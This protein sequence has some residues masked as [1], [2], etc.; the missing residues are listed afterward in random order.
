MR[1]AC[2]GAGKLVSFLCL[3]PGGGWPARGATTDSFAIENHSA[4]GLIGASA[5]GRLYRALADDGRRTVLLKTAAGDAPDAR[6]C[7]R[8][9]REY[10]FLAGLACPGVPR[11]QGILETAVSPVLV[12]EDRGGDLLESLMSGEPWPLPM[13]FP[14]ALSLVSALECLHRNHVVHRNIQPLSILFNQAE[15]EAHLINFQFASRVS[16]EHAALGAVEEIEGVLAYL[17]PEQTGRMNRAV[18]YRADFY[19]LGVIFYELL[20]G[21][22]P[23]AAADALE[24]V[25]CH[26]ARAPRA[27]TSVVAAIPE[28]LS[29]IVLRLLAKLAEDRY[30]SAAGLHHDLERCSREWRSV[31]RVEPF[32]IGLADNSDRFQLPQRLYGR[33]REAEILLEAFS[34]VASCGR[35]ELV[36][37]SG[38]SGI[39]KSALVAEL[40][41]PILERRGYFIAGKFDQYRRDRPYETLAEPFKSLV[42]QLLAESGER[43]AAWRTRILDAVGELGQLIV[44]LIPQI[45]LVIG[46]Q[47]SVPELPPDQAQYRL[48]RVFRRFVAAFTQPEQPLVL[49]FDDLQWVDTTSLNLLSLL[50]GDANT[51]H[52]LV[53]GAYRDNEVDDAHP[54]VSMLD[55]LRATTLPIHSLTLNPLTQH[56]VR[57]IIAATLRSGAAEVGPLAN[58]VY[59]KTRG[60]PFFTFQFLEMLHKDHLITFEAATGQWLWDVAAIRSRNFTDNVVELMLNEL[61]RLPADSREALT[62][63]GFLGNRFELT[64][65][66]LVCEE[67][68]TLTMRRLWPAIK[69][70]LLIHRYGEYH[71]LH[72]RVQEAAYL[73]TPVGDRAAMHAQI[74]RLLLHADAERLDERLFDIAAH[75]NAGRAVIVDQ[76]ERVGTAALNQRAGVRARKAAIFTAAGNYYGAGISFLPANPWKAHYDLALALHLGLA[77]CEYLQG[78]FLEAE[79]LLDIVVENANSSIDRA[80]AHMVRISLLVARGDSPAACRVA[81]IGLTD[82]GLDLVEHP[83]DEDIRRGYEEVQTLLAGRPVEYL[84]ELPE[85]ADPNMAMATRM[86]IFTSTAAYMTDVKLLA[87]HDTQMIVQCLRHGNVDSTVLGYVFYG[88][89]VANY[90]GRYREGYRFCEVAR[91]LME[92]RGLS[93]HRGSLIY[94]SAIVALWVRPI[95][96]CIQRLHDS[97]QPLL[98]SGNLVIA[99]IASRLIVTF[100]MLRGDALATVDEDAERCASFVA[101]LNYPAAVSLNRT[102]QQLIRR[103]RGSDPPVLAPADGSIGRGNDRIPFVIVAEHLAEVAWHCLMDQH[104]SAYQALL[105][106]RPL[107]WGTIGLL[108]IHDFFFYGSIS[109]AVR[110]EA[111]A[112]SERPQLLAWL[113]ANLEQLRLW[114]EGNPESF[115]A[116]RLLVAAEIARLEARSVDAL[117][118]FDEAMEAAR[119]NG[120]VQMH[121]LACERAALLCRALGIN[122]ASDRLLAQACDSYHQWGAAAKVQQMRSR[123]AYLHRFFREGSSRFSL[124]DSGPQ[125]AGVQGLDALALARASRAIA[126]QLVR[127]DLLRTLMEVMLESGGAQ[128]GA[129][130]MIREGEAVLVATAEVQESGIRTDL[131]PVGGTASLPWSLLAYVIRSREA[132][133]IDDAQR[134]HRFGSEPWFA[135]RGTRSALGLPI[136]HSRRLIGV[137]Y[138]EHRTVPDVFT[139]GQLSIMEQLAAQAAVSIENSQ[140][141]ERLEDH[142]RRLQE[143]VEQ[144]TAELQRSRNTLQSIIEHSPAMMFLKDLDGRYLAHSPSLAASF[145][146]AGQSIIGL[147]D[148]DLWPNRADAENIRRSD[149]EVARTDSSVSVT[150]FNVTPDGTRTFM[151]CKFAVPDEQGRTYAVGAVALDVTE[152]KAAK[153]AAESAT[154]AKSEFLANVSHEIRT[155]MNAILGMSHLALQTDLDPQQRDYVRKVERSA[156]LLLGV[157]NDI[158]DFSKIEAGKLDMEN[159]NFDLTDV[160]DNLGSLVGLQSESKG[161]ELLFAQPPDLPTHLVGDP[162]RLSQVL[163]NLASNAVKFTERGEVV[164]SVEEIERDARGVLLRFA[165]RDTGVG[166]TWD[167]QQ[168]LFRAFEQADS[169]T[170]RRYGG[171]GLGLAISR[172]LVAMMGGEID[173]QSSPGA[174]STFRFSARFELQLPMRSNAAAR[175]AVLRGARLL[176]VDD[177]PTARGILLEMARGLGLS[178][179]EAADGS[180]A[181]R[182]VSGAASAGVPFDLVVIDL[183][184]PGMDGIEC[185]RRMSADPFVPKPALLMLSASGRDEALRQVRAFNVQVVDALSKPLTPSTLFDACASALGRAVDAPPS[186]DRRERAA[187]ETP[188]ALRGARVLLVED[189]EINMELALELLSNA[190]AKV[191]VAGDGQQALDR[192][193]EGNFDIVLLDCQMPVMDGYETI[194]AIRADPRL[195]DLPV[196][197]MTA[198]AMSGDRNRALSAGMDD[199]IAKPVDVASMLST[200]ARWLQAKAADRT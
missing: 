112:S 192:L 200:I 144:R 94:H 148:A 181:L 138:L 173:V 36:M 16:R 32:E 76:A 135:A 88:F 93:Q 69:V 101:P 198:N 77:E 182:K 193:A 90:L 161:L 171:T 1:R 18:D 85:A 83:T 126:S 65:L 19:S 188:K 151:I 59:G 127:E 98:E 184:M 113:H 118:G 53:I 115:E 58:I 95:G 119:A 25:H 110:Y 49:F 11:A 149:L 82:L 100:R 80:K 140:L 103:L 56:H 75:M 176:I 120:Q 86:V 92:R 23:F 106:A 2:P 47:P 155:P 190:G 163:V 141:I 12:L 8:L 33:E 158:L 45:A 13:F 66:A 185:A 167:Q 91:E 197:A 109:I 175:I 154:R 60:N 50:C 35:P 5:D 24:M 20:T 61:L 117:R 42:Q 55:T 28:P 46:A 107:M 99:G 57:E 27:L 179:E 129:L 14:L 51:R 64:T 187:G 70:G 96:E 130:S 52:L 87:Y 145:G 22:Q 174:G 74:G 29:A 67:A 133:V 97:I 102:T 9:R 6:E 81:Q 62:R 134:S 48:Q 54:L 168:R 108:P 4:I 131:A 68:A 199:H 196:I 44:D 132:V 170:S 26:L 114:S 189:N 147:T 162:L 165:V 191:T 105:L 78:G 41:R 84:L 125:R 159:V 177:N 116:G 21:R 180:E 122:G 39:G 30:Q 156:R 195:R 3:A 186:S 164:V 142:Q 43:I 160:M 72:D 38:Y 7:D 123:Y 79:R 153:D 71:F 183:R 124:A 143:H 128:F 104:E 40:H 31:Q 166:M 139:A 89:I 10:E 15:G 146:R 34:R 136:Q 17:A 169:S 73:L 137:L 178:A 172:H 63:A 37:V 152:L 111:A 157:L 194:Q 150:R 121:A